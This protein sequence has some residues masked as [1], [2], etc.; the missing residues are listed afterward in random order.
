[1]EHQPVGHGP[2]GRFVEALQAEFGL[3]LGR[4]ERETARRLKLKLGRGD[5]AVVEAFDGDFALGVLH[6]SEQMN[7]RP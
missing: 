3:Y 7:E 1:M 4:I 6:R 5:D 2:V